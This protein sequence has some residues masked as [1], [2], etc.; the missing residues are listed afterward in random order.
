MGE[1]FGQHGFSLIEMAVAIVVLGIL[2]AATALFLRGPIALNTQ[3]QAQVRLMDQA[4]LADLWLERDLAQALPGSFTYS[5][6]GAGFLLSFT[7]RPPATGL[8]RYLCQPDAANP[9]QGTLRRNGVIVADHLAACRAMN[10]QAAA[11]RAAGGRQQF[12][13]LALV[14]RAGQ[15]RLDMLKGV[16]VQP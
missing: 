15:A 12:V 11:Y 6:S 2:A 8:V 3:R 7:P 4:A 1:G 10:P 14:F 16:R 13:T 9:A 5:A